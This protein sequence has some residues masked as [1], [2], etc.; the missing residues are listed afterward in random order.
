MIEQVELSEI[1]THPDNPRQGDIGLI[2]S[3]IT[4]NGW[5]GVLVVQASTRQILVGNHRY[6]AALALGIDTLP[7]EWLDC[8][9]DTALRILLADNASSDAASYDD[10]QLATLLQELTQTPAGLLGTGQTPEDL[11]EIVKRVNTPFTPT[12]TC[13]CCGQKLKG[14]TDGPTNQA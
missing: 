13:T 10:T 1:V 14:T 2:S 8:D 6:L 12:T 9:D 7:V 3:L 4:T 11:D 5:Y